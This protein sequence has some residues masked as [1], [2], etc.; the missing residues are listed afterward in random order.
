MRRETRSSPARGGWLRL[1]R[2]D[3]GLIALVVGTALVLSAAPSRAQRTTPLRDQRPAQDIFEWN[4]QLVVRVG[5]RQPWQDLVSVSF[6]KDT[7]TP[8]AV[9]GLDQV[10]DVA[11]QGTAPVAFGLVKGKPLLLRLEGGKW[12]RIPLP[13]TPLKKPEEVRLAADAQRVA[14]LEGDGTAHWRGPKDWRSAAGVPIR[15]QHRL[16][17]VNNQL[18]IGFDVGEWGGGLVSVNLESGTVTAIVAP[19]GCTT[20]TKALLRGPDD[21]LWVLEGQTHMGA[22]TGRLRVFAGGGWSTLASTNGFFD[23]H[24]VRKVS[25]QARSGARAHGICPGDKGDFFIETARWPFPPASFSG[26]A[27]DVQG[28]PVVLADDLGLVRLEGTR[29]KR[30][31]PKWPFPHYGK[32]WDGSWVCLHLSGDTAVLGTYSQGLLVW[33]LKTKSSRFIAVTSARERISWECKRFSK[34]GADQR[35]A[36]ETATAAFLAR[37][38]KQPPGPLRHTL[39]DYDVELRA[40]AGGI[41]IEFRPRRRQEG[42]VTKF[43]VKPPYNQIAPGT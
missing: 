17:L 14:L 31:T 35:R 2:S 11:A 1:G 27:F 19:T 40:V 5:V 22:L 32:Y 28:R 43:L 42:A 20:P 37:L 12:Q 3:C 39:E 41:E 33:N 23:G 9:P 38:E 21:K 7:A 30:L 6:D 34:V 16:V 18:F 29:W 15:G 25:R 24:G 4:G 10:V 8:L 26:L 13:T 36:C